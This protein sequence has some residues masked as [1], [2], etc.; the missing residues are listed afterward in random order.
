MER[1]SS[2]VD[3]TRNHDRDLY[4]RCISPALP[5]RLKDSPFSRPTTDPVDEG[6]GGKDTRPVVGLPYSTLSYSR[7]TQDPTPHHGDCVCSV[8]TTT[9]TN[10]SDTSLKDPGT[11]ILDGVSSTTTPLETPRPSSIGPPLPSPQ[12]LH[13]LVRPLTTP[14]DRTLD[15]RTEGTPGRVQTP[16]T[17]IRD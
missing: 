16:R 10:L 4:P 9:M 5:G 1:D 6:T 3:G 15:G 8:T 13:T 14:T 7:C 17:E 11:L 12:Y 2:T